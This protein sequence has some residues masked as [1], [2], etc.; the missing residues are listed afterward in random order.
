MTNVT[1][2]F[3]E[4]ILLS[5]HDVLLL[6][7][8]HDLD[9]GEVSLNVYAPEDW[10]AC[11]GPSYVIDEDSDL[12]RHDG[13]RAYGP[14]LPY[15]FARCPSEQGR[16]ER[17]FARAFR[18]EM[19]LASRGSPTVG[20]GRWGRPARSVERARARREVEMA[21]RGASPLSL[22][23]ARLAGARAPHS[24]ARV[25]AGVAA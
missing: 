16:F 9:T 7:P 14:A 18:D 5:G 22:A 10:D 15:R 19:R 20:S 23:S 4:R 13:S 2:G 17:L 24:L 21:I 12:R 11:S 25:L 6:C 1:L 3:G 8:D